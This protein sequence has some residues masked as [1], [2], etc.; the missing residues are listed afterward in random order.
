MN[1]HFTSAFIGKVG[2]GKTTECKQIIKNYYGKD[3]RLPRKVLV[4]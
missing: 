1:E 4:F 2:C 3:S